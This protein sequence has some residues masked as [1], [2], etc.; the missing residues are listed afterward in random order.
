MNT[1]VE[2][3][4][5][6]VTNTW[7]L[8]DADRK[9]GTWLAI[10]YLFFYYVRPQEHIPGLNALPISGALIW[11]FTIWGILHI[12]GKILKT[13]I[14]FI[15]LLALAYLFSAFGA[16]NVGAHR[17]TLKAFTQVLPQ[18]IAL[19]ILFDSLPR[20]TL[21]LKLWCVIYFLMSLITIKDGGTGPGDFSWD[22]NDAALALGMGLPIVFYSA[23]LPD[24]SKRT[25]LLILLAA[26]VVIA[27]VIV[28]RS[29]G[30]FLGLVGSLLIIWWF[31]RRRIKIA[32]YAIVFSVALSGILISVL[33]EG[34]LDEMQSINNAEDDT[35]VERLRL[36]ETAW[37]MY[38]DNPVFGVGVYNQKYNMNKYQVYTSWYT[39]FEI[40]YQGKVVHSLYFQVLSE[41]GTFGAIIYLFIMIVL[42]LKLY[43]L[44]R[45]KK[46]EDVNDSHVQLMSRA[47]IASMGVFVVSGAF[48]SVAYYPHIYIWVTMYAIVKR[49]DDN[50]KPQKKLKPTRVFENDFQSET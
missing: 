5:P 43:G 44:Q 42:P 4:A 41:T 27:G 30:G 39:G 33:P 28:T 34:Y 29:R 37:E 19:Y 14:Y 1:S 20:A 32:L 3:A 50:E 22:N 7:S 24:I 36:W 21:L 49:F 2:I 35:R 12:R 16:V 38:K 9:Y 25:K 31:S 10:A 40:N 26:V 48:I 11:V 46:K 47:L 13:P 6:T 17:Y 23:F 45:R 18:C 8:G 15:V